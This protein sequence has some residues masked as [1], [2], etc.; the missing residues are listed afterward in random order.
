M[1]DPISALDANVKK[2]I[3]DDVLCKELWFKTRVLV[4]HSPEIGFCDFVIKMNAGKISSFQTIQEYQS[5]NFS[6]QSIE[7][8]KHDPSPPSFSLPRS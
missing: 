5:Q 8:E 6:I 3:I 4:T 2:K 1:D 7:E